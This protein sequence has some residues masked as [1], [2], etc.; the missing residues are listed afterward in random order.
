MPPRLNHKKSRNGCQR[1]KSR[2]VKCDEARPVCHNCRRHGTLCEYARSSS[3][4]L[5][6]RRTPHEEL[7]A[8]PNTEKYGEIT[9]HPDDRRLLE[10]QLFYHYTS[11]VSHTIPSSESHEVLSAYRTYAAHMC[12]DYPVLL[13][14]TL[15]LSAWHLVCMSRGPPPRAHPFHKS[16]RPPL[17]GRIDA[18]QAHHFYL[19]TAVKQ[20]REAI[21]NLDQANADAL[22]LAT[23]LLAYQPLG[24]WDQTHQTGENSTYSPPMHW[25]RMVKGISDITDAIEAGKEGFLDFM[26]SQA[27]K[28]NFN[29]LDSVFDPDNTQPFLDLLDFETYPEPDGDD[30]TKHTYDMALRYI[31]G[32]YRGIQENEPPSTLF[33]RLLCLGLMAPGQFLDFIDARRPRALAMLALYCST[34]AAID[35]HWMF[36][37]MAERE[38]KGLQTL[39]PPEW[40]WSM[41]APLRIMESCLSK[42]PE[43]TDTNQ[44]EA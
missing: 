18:N 37:G 11:V 14:A 13:N 34:A 36:H 30:T 6:G 28:P 40:Q 44:T 35:Y 25:L 39:L 1:C 7:G 33:R 15:A 21:A 10:L 20:Q 27:S 9:L 38:V 41:K 4:G 12:F 32:I 8:Q 23:V 42:Q 26:S 29:D 2:K 22:V 19:T 17:V 3:S 24:L 16:T 43:T 31:G 5:E